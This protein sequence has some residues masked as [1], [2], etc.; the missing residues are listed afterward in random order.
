MPSLCMG[1]SSLKFGFSESLLCSPAVFL[2]EG[3]F[4]LFNLTEKCLIIWSVSGI[5]YFRDILELF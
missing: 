3:Q 1:Q 5:S 2:S 4:L